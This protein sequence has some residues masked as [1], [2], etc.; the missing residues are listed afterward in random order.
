MFSF[1]LPPPP[2][3]RRSISMLDINVWSGAG[4]RVGVR[5][6]LR[7]GV[8]SVAVIPCVLLRVT[9][10]RAFGERWLFR[11]V[12]SKRGSGLKSRQTT[13]DRVR[14]PLRAMKPKRRA[15]ASH[16]EAVSTCDDLAI[17]HCSIAAG[18][19]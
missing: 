5:R 10:R 3:L 15:S 2:C 13:W 4:G 11:V 12:G 7:R 19:R 8:H 17:L 1:P 14:R 6:V 16:L 9:A 18:A